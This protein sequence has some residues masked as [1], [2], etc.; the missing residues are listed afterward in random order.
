MRSTSACNP[1]MCVWGWCA[2]V[3]VCGRVHRNLWTC[4]CVG[5]C[6][7][8]CASAGDYEWGV[9]VFQRVSVSLCFVWPSMCSNILII[10]IIMLLI[11]VWVF[12]HCRPYLSLIKWHSSLSH[13]KRT[14]NFILLLIS[15]I[16]LYHGS[17]IRQSLPFWFSLSCCS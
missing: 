17:N 14:I 12:R 13:S 11:F 5:V 10:S 7:C 3:S 6:V 8:M 16:W 9:F 2:C 15:V 4:V 1:S